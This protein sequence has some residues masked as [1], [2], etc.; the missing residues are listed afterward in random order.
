MKKTYKIEV[1]CANCANLIEAATKKVEGVKDASVAFMT[2]KMKVEFED[3]ADAESV[4]A[5]VLKAAKKIEPDFEI[6]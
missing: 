1:D 6:L 3:D 5:D 2:Q 4:M